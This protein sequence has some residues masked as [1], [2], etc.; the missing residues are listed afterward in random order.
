MEKKWKRNGTALGGGRRR[1]R[2]PQTYTYAYRLVSFHIPIHIS[3]HKFTRRNSGADAT[4][5]KPGEKGCYAPGSSRAVGIG[6]S[7]AGAH[8]VRGGRLNVTS[9]CPE[10]ERE[11]SRGGTTEKWGQVRLFG[12]GGT[13]SVY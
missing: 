8:A 3:I 12:H 1:A 2:N 4:S 6:E 7:I 9:G 13:E 5:K 10:G 11:C